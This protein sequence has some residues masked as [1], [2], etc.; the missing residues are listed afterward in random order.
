MGYS[1]ISQHATSQ[2]PGTLE[3]VAKPEKDRDWHAGSNGHTGDQ[4]QSRPQHNQQPRPTNYTSHVRKVSTMGY[5]VGQVSVGVVPSEPP[6]SIAEFCEPVVVDGKVVDWTAPSSSVGN[7]PDAYRYLRKL[8]RRF[9][10]SYLWE[11]SLGP[12]DVITA[13]VAAYDQVSGV[14]R[15]PIPVLERLGEGTPPFMIAPND[16]QAL[17]RDIESVRLLFQKSEERGWVFVDT[18]REQTSFAGIWPFSSEVIAVT[19]DEQ[20]VIEPDGVF[21]RSARPGGFN[22]RVDGWIWRSVE[23]VPELFLLTERGD[24]NVS[25]T[26]GSQLILLSSWLGGVRVQPARLLVVFAKAISGLRDGTQLA[27]A[28]KRPLVL[29]RK[30]PLTH[31]V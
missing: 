15:S 16:A 9:R 19:D 8:L 1:A 18:T 29:H 7:D 5:L 3:H 11:S 17:F 14:E 2:S 4:Q 27:E 23:S 31:M 6:A 30:V 26:L 25:N 28:H 10:N 12:A 20:V 22:D 13:M 21:Y 24:V